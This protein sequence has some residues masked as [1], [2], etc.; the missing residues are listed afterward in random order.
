MD[1]EIE[2]CRSSTETLNASR[3]SGH[4]EKSSLMHLGDVERA[5]RSRKCGYMWYGL[6]YLAVILVTALVFTLISAKAHIGSECSCSQD[7]TCKISK[8]FRI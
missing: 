2:E 7:A 3:T 5:R 1:P 4:D 8:R 6:S